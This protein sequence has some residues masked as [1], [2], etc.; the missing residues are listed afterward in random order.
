MHMTYWI[1]LSIQMGNSVCVRA[2]SLGEELTVPSV[3]P[4]AALQGH[5]VVTLAPGDDPAC[6][7]HAEALS[8]LVPAFTRHQN[9][10]SAV[11]MQTPHVG[12][13]VTRNFCGGAEQPTWASRHGRL[14]LPCEK[15]YL[16]TKLDTHVLTTVS[17][18][19]EGR[20][21]CCSTTSL[22]S[23]PQSCRDS[24][25]WQNPLKWLCSA[26]F[27]LAWMQ[28]RQHQKQDVIT[29]LHVMIIRCHV[30]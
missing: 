7:S 23:L 16:I 8:L 19:S 13:G 11:C 25:E 18:L 29:W 1:L 5:P 6:T 30:N 27:L 24:A 10:C 28:V 26:D 22:W 4:E 9:S 15:F 21:P 17:F 14:D 2:V 20:C 12:L 3:C